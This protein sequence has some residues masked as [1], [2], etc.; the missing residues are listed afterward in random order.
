[1][2]AVLFRDPTFQP[3]A[4]QHELGGKC[5]A[6][7]DSALDGTGL[8]FTLSAPPRH[9][10]TEFLGRATPIRA[11]LEAA[12]RGEE[13]SI[14]YVTSTRGRAEEVS[15]RVRAAIERIYAETGD[16]QWAPG[17]KWSTTEWET[18][19]GHEWYGCGW[20]T[21]TGGIGCRLLIM[22]DMLGS[23][24]VYRSKAKRRAIRE[25]VKGDLLSRLE[26]GGSAVQMETRRGKGDTTDWL[27]TEFGETWVP[28]VWKCHDPA[29]GE[30]D[31]AYLWP[32]RFGTAWRKTMPH[33]RD[34]APVWRS[35]YQQEPVAEGGTLIPMEDLENVYRETPQVAAAMADKVVIGADLTTTKK[36]TSDHFCAVVVGW[37]G[38][39]RDILHVVHRKCGYVEQKR[40]L[41]DLAETWKANE[42]RVER[43]A[44]GDAMVEDLQSSVTGVT[45]EWPGTDK[46]ARLT[47]H[48]GTFAAKQ[49]RVP[50]MGAP[51]LGAWREELSGFSGLE[52][53]P[54][55]QV[56]ATVWALYKRAKGR[57]PDAKNVETAVKSVF[58]A[59][60]WS[61]RRP[62]PRTKIRKGYA[63]RNTPD[64]L[65]SVPRRQHA[66]QRRQP[67][68]LHR[69]N[70]ASR[71]TADP[72]RGP[73]S[74]PPRRRRVLSGR[75]AARH[76][77]HL[78]RVVEAAQGPEEGG[79][80]VS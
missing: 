22:D 79:A 66:V 76:V 34:S 15:A 14:M 25:A 21:A 26:A 41:K 30:G 39:Y 10:K 72:R 29:R 58:G 71:G 40:I 45:G 24:A 4:W 32:A 57:V 65:H 59:G 77:G 48:L 75:V 2:G 38:P 16:E 78:C 67:H 33:L 11:Y 13:M 50:V 42:V 53:D 73:V 31:A 23:G 1:M 37:R 18:K 44:G 61:M 35:L 36:K 54:D 17:R 49:V 56:D 74:R 80:L 12:S 68:H 63:K 20:S 27:Q 28:L 60:G 46:V 19:G 5:D 51:W 6:L 70:G 3:V 7:I 47:P 43:A 8:R 69:P 52:A 55:N 62:G 64:I 9:G